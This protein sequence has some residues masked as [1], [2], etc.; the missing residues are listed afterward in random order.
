MKS[1]EMRRARGHPFRRAVG[2]ILA[3]DSVKHSASLTRLSFGF[4][5]EPYSL[6]QHEGQS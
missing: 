3:D 6:Q 4:E 2:P 1:L 5:R